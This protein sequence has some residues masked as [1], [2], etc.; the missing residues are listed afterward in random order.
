MV[1]VEALLFTMLVLMVRGSLPAMIKGPTEAS[2]VMLLNMPWTR[3]LLLLTCSRR[4]WVKTKSSHGAGIVAV[5]QLAALRML[6][7]LAPPIH[8]W[9]VA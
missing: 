9:V 8:L 6:A 3:L 7:V 5:S 4:L 1:W 2:K